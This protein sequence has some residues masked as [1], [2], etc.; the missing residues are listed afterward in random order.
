VIAGALGLTPAQ[1][2]TDLQSGKTIQ[3]IVTAQGMTMQQ[4][5]Q[6]VLTLQEQAVNQAAAAGKLTQDQA[7][8]II[9]RLEQRFNSTTSASGGTVQS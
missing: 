1:I 8:K 5:R 3:Q 4:F 6:K 9:Q 7:N 2:K